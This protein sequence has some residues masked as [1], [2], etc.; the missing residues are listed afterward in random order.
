M[1]LVNLDSLEADAKA[2]L[3]PMAFAYYA[4]GAEEEITLR[5]N[6]RSFQRLS[7]MYRVLR[8]VE[9]VN[10]GTSVLGQEISWPVLVAP[11]AFQR[12]AHDQGE[13]ATVRA[14]GRSGTIMML[15]TMSTTAMEEVAANATT[16]LWFQ[17]YIYKDRDATAGLVAR[18]E[19]AGCKAIVLTVDA[20]VLGRRE[21]DIEHRLHLPDGV[22]AENM[23]PSGY[24]AIEKTANGSGLAAYFASL[25]DPSISWRDLEWL[26]S[27]TKLPLLVKGIV[28]PDDALKALDHGASGIV[29]SNHGGRQL[30]T[31]PATIDVLPDIAE[32]LKHHRERDRFTLLMDGGIRRGTDVVKALALGADAV[33]LGR[34]V[35]W[36]LAK[37]GEEGVESAL[38]H[39]R[40][41]VANA[42]A[43]CG[44]RHVGELTGDLVR[45]LSRG[46]EID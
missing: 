35:L 27:I 21:R 20:P 12:L 31:A 5:E 10:T 18:A 8:N 30:D 37:A 29:V 34:P 28:R 44:C 4:S 42:M 7:L 9:S 22:T 41:A 43:L 14:A 25:L 33:L 16:P 32:A 36:A 13:I 11:M 17:L 15:S 6:R 3:S 45:P 40:E 1:E 2:K 46:G 24:Q 19:A 38:N 26:R 39:L 23:L